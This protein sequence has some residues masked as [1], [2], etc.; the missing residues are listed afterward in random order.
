M[1]FSGN[2]FKIEE[3]NDHVKKNGR[4]NPRKI[5]L[6]ISCRLKKPEIYFCADHPHSEPDTLFNILLDT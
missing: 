5:F 1:M 2:H 3:C 6:A 4:I